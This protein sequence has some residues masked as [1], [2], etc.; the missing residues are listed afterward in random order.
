MSYG[1]DMSSLQPIRN[2]K[3]TNGD[4]IVSYVNPES[5]SETLVLEHPCQLNLYK[6]KDS[7]LTYYFTRYMPLSSDDVIRLNVNAV[8]AYTNVSEEVE[9]KYIKAA[10]QYEY[11]SSEDEDEDDFEIEEKDYDSMNIH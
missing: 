3:L 11:G 8:V 10:L 6:E 7:S 5:S 9:A 1:E 2:I 4:Q